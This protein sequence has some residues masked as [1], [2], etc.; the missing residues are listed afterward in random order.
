MYNSC[1]QSINEM[2]HFWVVIKNLNPSAPKNFLR[3][4]IFQKRKL[5]LGEGMGL[6]QLGSS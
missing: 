1:N 6:A 4:P 2:S 5:R 3:V